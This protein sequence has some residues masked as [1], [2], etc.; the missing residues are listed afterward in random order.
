MTDIPE[1]LRQM[2]LGEETDST[3]YEETDRN[4][5]IIPQVDGT[6]NSRD[7]LD[8]TPDSIDLTK[9]PVKNINT[10][11]DIEK[12][13][14]DT[15]DDDTDDM[16]EFNKDKARMIYRKDTN[17]QR[18]RAKIVKSIK[19]RTTKVYAIN[20]E[21]KRL[22][23]QRRKKVLQ[24]AK[25]RKLVKANTPVALQASIRAN[26]ASK[27]TQDITMADNATTGTDNT[28]N[29]AIDA[30][31]THNAATDRENTDDAV[32]SDNN[33]DNAATDVDNTDDAA[34]GHDNTDNAV[35]GKASTV[36]IPLP[37]Q[38][39]GKAKGPSQ[40]KTSSKHTTAIAEPS[41]G[42]TLLDGQDTVKASGH[43]IYLSDVNF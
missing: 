6:V 12:I 7:S 43:T 23:K 5:N 29:A 39:G 8:W 30:E 1:H 10:Q 11:R 16:I 20:I 42:D 19:G 3:S 41:T 15:S 17:E 18:K 27:D 32:T 13:N 21:R 31:N 33:I 38:Y 36:H 25:D 35:I 9:S 4:R 2:S 14:E 28:D 40:I 22:L 26:R 34:I 24:N 37:P